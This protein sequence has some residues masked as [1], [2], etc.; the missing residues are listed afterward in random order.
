MKIGVPTEIKADEHRVAP[1]PAGVREL[2]DRG[3]DVLVQLGAGHGLAIEDADYRAQGARIVDDAEAV[4]A[5][6]ELIVKV[7]E[8]QP[9]E[10]ELPTR[11][12]RCSPT[13]TSLPT[14]L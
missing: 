6:A 10:V 14:P 13:C 1:T 8:P 7:K 4:F 9:H 12:T 5:E 11:G 3:H 2:A